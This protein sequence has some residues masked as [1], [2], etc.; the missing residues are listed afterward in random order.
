[1]HVGRQGESPVGGAFF[2]VL[3]DWT[4]EVQYGEAGAATGNFSPFAGCIQQFHV[5][6]VFS[7]TVKRISVTSFESSI[8]CEQT[9]GK[10]LGY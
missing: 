5:V 1:M 9:V 6:C 7:S 2:P 4:P 8:F 10:M 3:E